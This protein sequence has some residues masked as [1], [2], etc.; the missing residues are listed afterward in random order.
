MAEMIEAKDW[1]TLK[2][3]FLVDVKSL[4]DLQ[5]I[6]EGL[7]IPFIVYRGNEYLIFW[8]QCGPV[9]VCYRYKK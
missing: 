4:E 3:A 1:T 8:G 9:P 7:K 5:K 2:A 6:A